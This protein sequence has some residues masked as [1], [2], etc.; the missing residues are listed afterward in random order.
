MSF[1]QIHMILVQMISHISLLSSY[2]FTKKIKRLG[3]VPGTWFDEK[4]WFYNFKCIFS[5]QIIYCWICLNEENPTI[6]FLLYN[7]QSSQANTAFLIFHY[8]HDA[9]VM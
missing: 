1:A 3:I 2:V 4:G 7:S 9:E 5:W 6:P 8:D